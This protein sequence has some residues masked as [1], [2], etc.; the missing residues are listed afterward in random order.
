MSEPD[1]FFRAVAEK[2]REVR[3]A[4]A[5]PVHWQPVAGGE[6]NRAYRARSAQSLLFIKRN[7]PELAWMF[8]AEACALREIAA[9]G[10]LRVPQVLAVVQ[11]PAGSGLLL[12]HV[13]LRPLD[14]PA[15][16]SLGTRLAAMHHVTGPYYGWPRDNTIG[17]TPQPNAA[18]DDWIAFFRDLRLGHQLDLAEQHGRGR[19][20]LDSGRRLCARIMGLFTDYR[21]VPSLLHG[22]LWAGNAAM[23]ESARPIVYDP[24]SYWG[25][26]EADVA[27]TE[28]FGGFGRAFLEAYCAAWPL[29]P[30][31]RKRRGLYQLYHVLNHM[32]LFGG[33]YEASARQLIASLLAELRG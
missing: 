3:P 30:G 20:L 24:A 5:P 25:D 8:E 16:A 27:M 32:N 9:T 26:R 7:R 14:Q 18:H 22:D 28:L 15:R 31:Y 1:P 19:S 6:V 29:D 33:G 12:E 10:T 23:D 21:P 4:A 2:L 13:S 11:S 17:I